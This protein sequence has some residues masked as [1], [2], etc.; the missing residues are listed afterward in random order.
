MKLINYGSGGHYYEFAPESLTC[1]RRDLPVQGHKSAGYSGAA[2]LLR[3]PGEG[4]V[5][6]GMYL[7]EGRPWFFIGRERWPLY[8]EAVAVKHAEVFGGLQCELRVDQDGRRV[9]TFRYWRKGLLLM[10]IDPTYDH[11]DFSLE[12]LPVDWEPHDLTS[13]QKQREEFVK[14]W[15]RQPQ[16]DEHAA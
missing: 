5:L 9:R 12:N 15:S 1:S 14:I 2:Q 16:G 4:K 13:L 3:S 8:D 11:L 6:V 7:A 10:F